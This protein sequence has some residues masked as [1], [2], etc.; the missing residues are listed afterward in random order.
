MLGIYNTVKL[1]ITNTASTDVVVILEIP[2]KMLPFS[3]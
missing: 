1:I 3:Y 2:P